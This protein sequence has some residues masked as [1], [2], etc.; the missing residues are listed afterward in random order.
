MAKKAHT[1]RLKTN[2][3]P[4]VVVSTLSRWDFIV[5][6]GLDGVHNVGKLDCVLYEE[7]RNV[8]ADDVPVPLVGVELD[9]EPTN[10][11]HRILCE[12]RGDY[13]IPCKSGDVRTAL[14]REP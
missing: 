14:P 11:A 9:R 10:V 1:F 3:V 4:E 7:H 6:L 5:R 8:V 2:E 12:H 13:N